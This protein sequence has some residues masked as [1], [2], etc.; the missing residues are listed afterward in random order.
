MADARE[1]AAWDRQSWLL[2]K[3]HNVHATKTANLVRD[4]AEFNP[5]LVRACGTTGHGS[6]QVTGDFN[7]AMYDALTTIKEREAG[8][9]GN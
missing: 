8:D 2:Q 4:A 6:Q 9:N 5:L 3:L 1:F 7:R